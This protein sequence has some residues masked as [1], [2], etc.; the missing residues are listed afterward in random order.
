ME[1]PFVYLQHLHFPALRRSK[2]TLINQRDPKSLKQ[3]QKNNYF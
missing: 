1:Q 2:K 3:L